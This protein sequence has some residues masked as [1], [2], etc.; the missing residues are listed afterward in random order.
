MATR[1]STNKTVPSRMKPNV[2][3]RTDFSLPVLHAGV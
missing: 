2:A 1:N 3:D